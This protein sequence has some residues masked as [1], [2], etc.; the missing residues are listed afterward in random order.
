M[1]SRWPL[2]SGFIRWITSRDFAGVAP[3]VAGRLQSTHSDVAPVR[4]LRCSLNFLSHRS[5]EAGGRV[6]TRKIRNIYSI[7]T[8]QLAGAG[9]VYRTRCTRSGGFD[10]VREL[11]AKTK[12]SVGTVTQCRVYVLHAEIL[13]PG[14]FCTLQFVGL[15]PPAHGR[16]NCWCWF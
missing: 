5:P 1:A 14:L 7:F 2:G 16:S 13:M 4:H 10:C 6:I 15:S 12:L 9:V 8:R 11:V 3:S